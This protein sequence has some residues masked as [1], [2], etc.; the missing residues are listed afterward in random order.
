MK[1]VDIFFLTFLVLPLVLLTNTMPTDLTIHEFGPQS[2]G[3]PSSDI[4]PLRNFSLTDVLLQAR[5]LID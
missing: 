2:F 5:R 4:F 1:G 3:L